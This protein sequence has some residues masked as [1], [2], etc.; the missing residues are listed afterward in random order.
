MPN[1]EGVLSLYSEVFTP[2]ENFD[3]A[4]QLLLDKSHKL[5]TI[6]VNDEV[7]CTMT[8][9]VCR[10]LVGQGRPYMILDNIATHPKYVKKGLAK[11][12]YQE[13]LAWAKE[14]G[15]SKILVVSNK[16]FKAEKFYTALGLEGNSSKV[17]I[18]RL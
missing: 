3:A 7:V 2:S 9:I 8:A 14:L 13:A 11:T 5:L 18:Q 1:V 17:Y 4:Q 12:L 6:E 16:R 10:N 15:C